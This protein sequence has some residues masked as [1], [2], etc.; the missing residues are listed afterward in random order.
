MD[1]K[2]L[3]TNTPNNECIAASNKNRTTTQENRK[4]KRSRKSDNNILSTYFDIK[5]FHFNSDIYLQIKGCAM[6]TKCVPTYANTFMS[7]FEER[8][9]Y[10]LI[11]NK[12][13]SCL[14]FIDDIFMV[15]TKSEYQLKFFTNEINKHHSIKF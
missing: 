4:E 7:E 2:A 8:C 9:I 15:W 10:S 14:R 1:V 5:Q 13:S 6:G 11:K 12:S 3:Y